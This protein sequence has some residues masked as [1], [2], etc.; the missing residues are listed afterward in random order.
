V[1]VCVLGFQVKIF[2]S[3]PLTVIK[4]EYT[5]QEVVIS[6]WIVELEMIVS[7]HLIIIIRSFV[8]LFAFVWSLILEILLITMREILRVYGY[9]CLNLVCVC[10]CR[11]Y[12]M[13]LFIVDLIGKEEKSVNIFT[14]HRIYSIFVYVFV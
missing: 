8:L 6:F 3:L 5:E 12:F 13:H 10:V 4:R 2:N 9:C 1:C 14:G 7:V 11:D